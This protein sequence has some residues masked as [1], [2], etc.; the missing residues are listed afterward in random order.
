MENTTHE[1]IEQVTFYKENDDLLTIHLPSQID[2]I[3]AQTI[4]KKINDAIGDTK[5]VIFDLT[6]LTYSSS[7]GLRMLL[8]TQK[9]LHEKHQNMYIKNPNE[10]ITE[11]LDTTGF[12]KIFN[13]IKI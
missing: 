13:I 9:N 12:T 10:E 1:N 3:I 7:S 11:L 8:V 5:T 2:A 6:D 4:E